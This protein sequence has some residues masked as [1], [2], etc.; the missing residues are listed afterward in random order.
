MITLKSI[1]DDVYKRSDYVLKVSDGVYNGVLKYSCDG[2]LVQQTNILVM[3][4][5]QYI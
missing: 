3:Q 4:Y 5:S 1:C 2:L